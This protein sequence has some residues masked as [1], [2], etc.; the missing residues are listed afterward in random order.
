[1]VEAGLWYCPTHDGRPV[2]A[3]TMVER[4]SP[5]RGVGSSRADP[6][7]AADE[8]EVPGELA[9]G[10]VPTNR[11][12]DR[13]PQP[14]ASVPD[15]S[16]E[17]RVTALRSAPAPRATSDVECVPRGSGEVGGA[18]DRGV[19]RMSNMT[20]Q[21][22]GRSSFAREGGTSPLPPSWDFVRGQAQMLELWL[23]KCV[24]SGRPGDDARVAAAKLRHYAERLATS[25][26]DSVPIES[27][28]DS[29]RLFLEVL[30]TRLAR[31]EIDVTL[32]GFASDA[33]RSTRGRSGRGV[34]CAAGSSRE[35][36]AR[37]VTA[38]TSLSL[39]CLIFRKSYGT[40][41]FCF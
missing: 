30:G 5:L 39:V 27:E 1:M 31:V 40:A 6:G 34:P 18:V 24:P 38:A 19:K 9:G 3:P 8:A 36:R 16:A 26:V 20:T 17:D 4:P 11:G 14:R 37:G 21:P 13:V 12:P 29:L 10:F 28:E 33:V 35:A 32:R 22:S 15:R 7:G 25:P 23:R 41:L 2:K